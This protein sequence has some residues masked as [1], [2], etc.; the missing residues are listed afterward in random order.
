MGKVDDLVRNYARFCGLPWERA[1]AG[2]QRVWFVVYDPRDERRLRARMPEFSLV[3]KQAGRGWRHVDL[4]DEFGHWLAEL[5]YLE[6]YLECPE[7]LEITMPDFE[8]ALAEKL[9]AALSGE[10]TDSD[11]VVAVT[12]VGSLFGFT[13]TATIVQAIEPHIRGRLAIF[14]PGSYEDNNYRLFDA[15]DGWNYMA[16]P[17]TSHQEATAQ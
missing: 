4:A 7:D 16:I 6:S 5:E 13:K 12:G 2:A 3:T 11:T 10:G 17:I 8:S 9:E 14:F 1:M 15:R